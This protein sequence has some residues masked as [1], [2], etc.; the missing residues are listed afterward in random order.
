MPHNKRATGE[1]PCREVR[2]YIHAVD[3]QVYGP[4]ELDEINQWIAQGRVVPT[5]LLQ[6][7]DSQM[8]VA[9]TTIDGLTWGVNQSFSAYTPQ[10]LS[11]AKYELS[12]AWA[13]FA[14]SFVLCCLPSIG[15]HITLGIGG[16]V[17]ATMA[18][19]KGRIWALFPLVLNLL[20]IAFWLWIRRSAGNSVDIQQLQDQLKSLGSR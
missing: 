15:A 8:R 14:V 2:Y 3:G 9:A 12:G 13:C 10:V 11:T 6:P 18:Y 1:V 5:T 19:R 17:L 7:E 16:L 20:L 4:V